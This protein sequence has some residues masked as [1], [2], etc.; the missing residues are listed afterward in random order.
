[1]HSSLQCVINR[2]LWAMCF[3]DATYNTMDVM[4]GSDMHMCTQ[5]SFQDGGKIQKE[6]LGGGLSCIRTY[7]HHVG[8]DDMTHWGVYKPKKTY[9]ACNAF[10]Y[11][12]IKS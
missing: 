10:A 2:R 5:E 1:M 12:G 6:V 7:E 11:T 3:R 8:H 4:A 9:V